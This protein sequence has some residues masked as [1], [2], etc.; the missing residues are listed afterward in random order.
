MKGATMRQVKKSQNKSKG[1]ELHYPT[2]STETTG[3]Q[4]TNHSSYW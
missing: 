2:G 1:S 4:E 3:A